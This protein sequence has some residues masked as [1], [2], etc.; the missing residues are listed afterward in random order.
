MLI[1]QTIPKGLNTI[2]KDNLFFVRFSKLN[3]YN[4]RLFDK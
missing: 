1:L 3:V 4:S 2:E